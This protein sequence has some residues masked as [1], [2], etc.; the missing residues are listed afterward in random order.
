M[1]NKAQSTIVCRFVAVFAILCTQL[2]ACAADKSVEVPAPTVDI[3]KTAGGAQTAVVAGGCFWGMQGLYEH[4]IGV[5]HVESGYSGGA[6]GGASYD[7][8][9]NG[10][11]GHAEAIKITFDP[12]K[13]SYGQILQVFF[14]VAHDP[15]QRDR[16]GP[17]VG[18]QYRSAIFYADEN[19][20]RVA[21]SYIA[22]LSKSGVFNRPIVTQVS[23]LKGFVTAEAYHQDYLIKNPSSPY[24][25]MYDLPKIR[26][27]ER[28]LPTLYRNDA[29]TVAAID[30]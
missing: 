20:K 17:D 12:Q 23:P 9:S 18:S 24:I 16:Q 7:T 8:V 15:T 11:S 29:I 19:Q 13:V 5:K 14:S 2:S 25:V 21:Q 6:P 26:N 30:R 1:D 27:F 3:P 28:T 4:M 10:S 22:Q